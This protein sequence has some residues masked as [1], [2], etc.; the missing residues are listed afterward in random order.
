MAGQGQVLVGNIDGVISPP[1][2]NYVKRV[3]ARGNEQK[4]NAIVFRMDT[5]GGL[6]TSMREITRAILNSEVPVI[7]YVVPGGRAASAGMFITMAAHVAAMSPGTAIGAAS[8]VAL[9]DQQPNETLR[10]KVTN[11]AAEYIRSLAKLRGRNHDWPAENAVR[12]AESLD[13]ENALKL[14]VIDLVSPDLPTLLSTLNG[15][16]IS[17]NEQEKLTLQLSNVTLV[18]VDLSLADKFL[19]AISNPNI[20]FIL[21]SLGMLGLFFELSNPGSIFPGVLGGIALLLAFYSLGTLQANWAGVL[22]M[23]LAFALFIAEIFLPSHG[24]LG[25]GAVVSFILGALMLWSGRPGVQLGVD[26]RL[27]GAIAGLIT[28]TML[29]I[30]QAVVRSQRLQ[31]VTGV[32]WL[33]GKPVIVKTPL[34]PEG[35][36]LLEGERW[37]AR[38]V[39]GEVVQ[40]GETVYVEKVEGLTVWVT[41]KG[42]R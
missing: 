33:V 20:A 36:V 12:R 13:A 32:A 19:L 35:T 14:R 18:N 6:D 8:P 41:K 26:L 7:V 24:I 11:D 4:V 42:R 17:L 38:V 37:H 30:I 2:A 23:G 34:G 39:N 9:G 1:M 5:P 22:L 3:I 31:P 21:L 16:E 15:R 29:F 10:D 40:P 27:I 28:L 25:A